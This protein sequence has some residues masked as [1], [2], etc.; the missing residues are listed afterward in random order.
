MGCFGIQNEMHGTKMSKKEMLKKCHVLTSEIRKCHEMSQ[1]VM[2]ML[3]KLS[4]FDMCV[5]SK[6][7][8][9]VLNENVTKYYNNVTF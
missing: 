4:H 8:P 7:K 5:F 9:S 6:R 1:N 2:K 3:R